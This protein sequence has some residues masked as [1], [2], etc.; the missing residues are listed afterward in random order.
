MANN[1]PCIDLFLQIK[2][3]SIVE[4][5]CVNIMAE[6]YVILTDL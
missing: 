6:Y 1:L 2:L 4:L 5:R 3:F